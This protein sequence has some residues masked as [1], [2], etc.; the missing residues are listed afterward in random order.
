MLKV[1]F[2]YYCSEIVHLPI[3]QWL[4][5]HFIDTGFSECLDS[6]PDNISVFWQ[7]IQS[8]KK[9]RKELHVPFL[10]LANAYGSVS[11]ELLWALFFSEYQ[12]Q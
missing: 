8:A 6:L 2:N 10:D 4:H 5:W 3:K 9:E 12:C 7:Q 1:I 11:H